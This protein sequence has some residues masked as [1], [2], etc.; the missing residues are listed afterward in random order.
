MLESGCLDYMCVGI[1]RDAVSCNWVIEIEFK[2]YGVNLSLRAEVADSIVVAKQSICSLAVSLLRAAERWE[3]VGPPVLAELLPL[4][5]FQEYGVEL[6]DVLVELAI[7]D[8]TRGTPVSFGGV[9]GGC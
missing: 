9:S 4:E 8:I 2:Y 7:E 5:F 1:H 3:L 6:K